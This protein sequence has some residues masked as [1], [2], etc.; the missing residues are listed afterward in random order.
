MA[1]LHY[2]GLSEDLAREFTFGVPDIEDADS[3]E[4]NTR[5]TKQKSR[6]KYKKKLK[7]Q[8]ESSIPILRPMY[9]SKSNRYSYDNRNDDDDNDRNHSSRSERHSLL[10]GHEHGK[11]RYAPFRQFDDG[12]CQPRRHSSHDRSSNYSLGR[13]KPLPLHS[14]DW[15]NRQHVEELVSRD[16]TE[17]R[18]NKYSSLLASSSPQC[19]EESKNSSPLPRRQKMHFWRHSLSSPRRAEEPNIPKSE[20]KSTSSIYDDN[21]DD[22]TKR[23]SNKYSMTLSQHRRAVQQQE[24]AEAARQRAN[25]YRERKRGFFSRKPSHEPSAHGGCLSPRSLESTYHSRKS[26]ASSLAETIDAGASPDEIIAFGAVLNHLTKGGSLLKAK[27]VFKKEVK[28]LDKYRTEDLMESNYNKVEL[29]Q[30]KLPPTFVKHK[31]YNHE[32]DADNDEE[33]SVSTFRSDKYTTVVSE[34]DFE[35]ETYLGKETNFGKETIIGREDWDVPGAIT[36]EERELSNEDVFAGLGIGLN[37][38]GLGIELGIKPIKTGDSFDSD[39][40]QGSTFDSRADFTI[41]SCGSDD[42]SYDS[43]YD[44]ASYDSTSTLSSGRSFT[45]KN[46]R[47]LRA[48]KRKKKKLLSIFM[49][50]K[51]LDN[52]E[53]VDSHNRHGNIKK[54]TKNSAAAEPAAIDIYLEKKVTKKETRKQKK[55]MSLFGG[56]TKKTSDADV[57]DIAGRIRTLK[58]IKRKPKQEFPQDPPGEKLIS[59]SKSRSLRDVT[60]YVAE[61]AADSDDGRTEDTHSTELGSL[62][63]EPESGSLPEVPELLE[64]IDIAFDNNEDNKSICGASLAIDS[65]PQLGDNIS[66]AGSLVDSFLDGMDNVA[67][68]TSTSLRAA[69]SVFFADDDDGSVG[70][71]MTAA[72]EFEE[73]L[74]GI[75]DPDDITPAPQSE[76][77][78]VSESTTAAALEATDMPTEVVAVVTSETSDAKATV[79]DDPSAAPKSEDQSIAAPSETS[80]VELAS[81]KTNASETPKKIWVPEYAD[82]DEGLENDEGTKEEENSVIVKTQDNK[83]DKRIEGGSASSI[84]SSQRTHPYD[85]STASASATSRKGKSFRKRIPFLQFKKLVASEASKSRRRGNLVEVDDDSDGESS[86]EVDIIVYNREET[87]A[88]NH[89]QHSEETATAYDDEAEEEEETDANL[90]N[91]LLY[92]KPLMDDDEDDEP[93]T[94]ALMNSCDLAMAAAEHAVGMDNRAS[95]EVLAELLARGQFCCGEFQKQLLTTT[96]E[97]NG[98][99]STH[100]NEDDKEGAEDNCKL[101]P[102]EGQLVDD[103]DGTEDNYKLNPTE[104]QLV[105]SSDYAI[106]LVGASLGDFG[107]YIGGCLPPNSE[108]NTTSIQSTSP[109]ADSANAVEEKTNCRD[110]VEERDTAESRETTKNCVRDGADAVEASVEVIDDNNNQ[111]NNNNNNN[112]SSRRKGRSIFKKKKKGRC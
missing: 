56:K 35:A 99:S 39:V 48:L 11:E 9:V 32:F 84:S 20:N 52:D 10:F 104:G 107:A 64:D 75:E 92:P 90:S 19:Q 12:E 38:E 110:E 88:Y 28:M 8:E 59:A 1:A 29:R 13:S 47:R 46:L 41:S 51:K 111:C 14:E 50:G 95:P 83:E 106:A 58:Q 76:S 31:K 96:S 78:P 18:S 101:I 93:L 105:P 40:N 55:N 63:D 27:K 3:L 80:T 72:D 65:L 100:D 34:T 86:F 4:R 103:K 53:N 68:I 2:D 97:K 71:G 102:T 22:D 85:E 70:E 37:F 77:L 112:N 69:R 87:A 108:V 89:D 60:S 45:D 26:K 54:G 79:S 66:V 42:E 36:T 67:Q 57:G 17:R 16:Y 91:A 15:A 94:V 25:S 98:S 73:E 24:E 109:A 82:C 49:Q 30:G 7:E 43:E 81:S 5:D 61:A 6:G 44:D 33:E 21:D 23:K 74:K 62:L